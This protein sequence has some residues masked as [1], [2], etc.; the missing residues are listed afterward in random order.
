MSADRAELRQSTMFLAPAFLEVVTLEFTPLVDNEVFGFRLRLLNDF[1][2]R[3]RHL[4][5][6][7]AS[8]EDREPHG[9]P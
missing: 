9:S 6:R 7:R 1:V 2:D 4:L 5:G 8:H 3:R